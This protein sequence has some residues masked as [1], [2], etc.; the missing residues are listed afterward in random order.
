MA[1]AKKTRSKR[2]NVEITKTTYLPDILKK[3]HEL[4]K[5]EVHIGAEGN[6]ELAMIAGIHEYG[7]L[8]AKIPAR[9]FIGSG[10]K[11]SQRVISQLAKQGV[12]AI[13]QKNET[14]RGLLNKIGAA[15]QDK[16]L[17]NFDK[18]RTPSLSPRYSLRKKGRKNKILVQEQRL[19]DAITYTI[20]S[21]KGG[22]K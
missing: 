20:V 6:A 10:R 14:A 22:K 9:S 13:V 17:K 15:G 5:N 18:I 1:K 12:N 3:L 8:K 16:T 19:R 11:K 7:S 4:T 21:R 2:A